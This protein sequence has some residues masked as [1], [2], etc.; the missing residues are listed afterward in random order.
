MRQYGRWLA[1]Q[2]SKFLNEESTKLHNTVAG[3]LHVLGTP[4]MTN[5][6]DEMDLL[7]TVPVGEIHDL[8]PNALIGL[9]LL[10]R[11]PFL[12]MDFEKLA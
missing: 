9:V 8:L 3:H 12:Q 10:A 11:K 6:L 4:I 1:V 7:V 2:C 5:R